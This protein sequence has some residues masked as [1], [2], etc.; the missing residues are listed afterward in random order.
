PFAPDPLTGRPGAR[1]Y[2]SG[3]RVRRRTD[4]CI[5]FLGRF[6]RQVKINGK[7]VELDEVEASLRR[8]PLV[9]DAVAVAVAGA[10]KESRIAA[11]VTPAAGTDEHSLAGRLRAFIGAELPDYMMPASIDLLAALPLSPMGK[12]DR[13][14][15]PPPAHAAAQAA[16]RPVE[17][18][19]PRDEI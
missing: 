12:V 1:L 4:G 10:N 16:A 18:R 5:E 13:T 14:K 9:G 2:R 15:L 11:Y 7:R 19:P 3:D 17:A 8:C 6:D